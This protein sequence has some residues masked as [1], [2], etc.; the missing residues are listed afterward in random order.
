MEQPAFHLPDARSPWRLQSMEVFNWGPFSG[1]HL[2]EIDAGGTAI[3]GMT[4]SGKTTLVDAFMTLLT[5]APK[6]NLAST[7]GHESDRSLISYVR[8]VI[9]SDNSSGDGAHISRKGATTTGLCAT[10][11]DGRQLV[12]CA[13]LLWIEGVSTAYA[14]LKRAWIFSRDAAQGL[15]HWLTVLHDGGLRA[16]KHQLR[17][18]DAIQIFDAATGGKRAYLARLRTFFEVGDNAFDL[19]NRAAGLKQLNSIDELFR[20]FVL[21][22]RSAFARALEVANDFNTL[23]DIHNELKLA[24]DQC[25]A[26]QPVSRLHRD[27][28]ECDESLTL[29]RE[30]K[31]ILPVWFAI[32]AR[33]LWRER[34]DQLAHKVRETKDRL[35]GLS[36]EV[37]TAKT[38]ESDLHAR[39]LQAGG[40]DIQSLQTTIELLEKEAGRRRIVAKDLA[41]HSPRFGLPVPAT[42]EELAETQRRAEALVEE[43]DAKKNEAEQ[44]VFKIG[45]ALKSQEDEQ[46]RFQKERDEV[47][48]SPSSNLPGPYQRF[49]AALA[50][51]IGLAPSD[52]PFV[53]ELIQVKSAEAEWR[54]AIERALGGHRLRILVP[55]EQAGE[56]LRWI[57]H[58]DNHLHVRLWEASLV[59]PSSASFFPDGFVR[60]LEFKPHALREPLKVFLASHDLHCVDSSEALRH[61]PHALTREGATS[62]RKGYADK[63]DQQAL[64][65]GWCTGF[66][67]RDR[68]DYLDKQIVAVKQ[69]A[70]EI[71]TTL[72][73]A[74]A[75]VSGL[76]V[77]LQLLQ[78]YAKVAFDD[79]DVSGAEADCT[80]QRERLHSLLAPDSDA[81]RALKDYDEARAETARL[82]A[83]KSTAEKKNGAAENEHK[84]AAKR[85]QACAN[86]VGDGLIPAQESLAREHLMVPD[87]TVAEDI[88]DFEREIRERADNALE[89]LVKQQGDLQKALVREMGKAKALDN[90]PLADAGTDLIDIPAYLERLRVLTEEA[91]PAKL[92]RFLGYLNKAS[93]EGVTQLLGLVKEEV[94]RIEERIADLNRSLEGVDFK[95]GCFLQLATQQVSHDSVRALELAQRQLRAAMLR[96]D[97]Q[98]ES[99]YQ[100]LRHVVQL[101]RE[102]AEKKHTVG[103]RALLDARFRLEFRGVEIDRIT[104]S[105][106]PSFKG[107]QGG[108]GG[109]KEIIASYILTAS[110]SYALSADGIGRPLHAT[111]VLDE[112]FSKSSRAVARRIAKAL[113][114]FGLHPIFVT[115][116]KE[117]RLLRAHTQS[118][119]HVH[120]KGTRAVLAS[121]RWEELDARLQQQTGTASPQIADETVPEDSS[122]RAL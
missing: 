113:D 27:W 67:N 46:A 77:D 71:R 38:R 56:A 79:I 119:V 85:E 66:D 53:A 93:D 24:R 122:T 105:E 36:D 32:N 110:L 7:G 10:Y 25:D 16:L 45:S 87:S 41:I 64:D 70:I 14:D 19:L 43:T 118:V 104:R 69:R 29:R 58:R 40:S 96:T 39:Y 88:D 57:N 121:I 3:I 99:H 34:A 60:K 106:G 97:D 12:R 120:R 6:Y 76:A 50:A 18:N 21:D 47:A 2:A 31:T 37:N 55:S 74:R 48:A 42:A 68:L 84:V 111:V 114:E 26:L 75:K 107:S 62:G 91:L 92:E 103:A 82:D 28:K 108:S 101:L 15:E 112:A 73:P 78:A 54:G 51:K 23:T 22:D 72:T 30:L 44:E 8:G 33:R 89:K 52:I 116:N 102:A 83:L 81:A 20:E 94:T 61:T 59:A 80:R 11:S 17:D 86:R 49:R 95:D 5:E 35:D 109:E 90:G 13:G 100:A 65:E 117:V 9:G 115:P 63:M 1:L 98:G 4:G